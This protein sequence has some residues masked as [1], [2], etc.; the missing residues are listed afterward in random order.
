MKVDLKMIQ[1]AREFLKGKI[2]ETP[3][4]TA[5]RMGENVYIKMEN[6]QKTGSFKI[7]GAY[8]KMANLTEV[9]ET[10]LKVLPYQRL[11]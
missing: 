5:S 10:T 1:E 8:N 6:L 9:L 3:I 4:F 11:N 2:S 7:R